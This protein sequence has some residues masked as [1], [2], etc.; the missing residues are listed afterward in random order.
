MLGLL[1]VVI[2]A[3]VLLWLL[4]RLVDRHHRKTWGDATGQEPGK[5]TSIESSV[6]RFGSSDGGGGL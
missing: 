4:M 5:P 3:A 2:V 6:A 1:V